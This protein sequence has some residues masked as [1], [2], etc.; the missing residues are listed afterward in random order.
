MCDTLLILR[1]RGLPHRTDHRSRLPS[2]RPAKRNSLAK[3]GQKPIHTRL[4]FAR[5]GPPRAMPGASPYMARFRLRFSEYMTDANRRAARCMIRRKARVS[6][7][8]QTLPPCTT[9]RTRRSDNRASFSCGHRSK[10]ESG[11]INRLH[12]RLRLS[13][14]TCSLQSIFI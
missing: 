11:S 14:P 9:W 1:F 8:R 4:L 7:D 6:H 13:P 10:V 2:H 3:T 12:Q 5:G